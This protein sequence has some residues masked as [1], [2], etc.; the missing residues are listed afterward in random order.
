[1]GVEELYRKHEGVYSTAVGYIGG[2]TDE[3]T[4]KQVCA[5]TT[6]HAEAVQVHF[7]AEEVSFE[8]LLNIFWDNHNPTTLNR[9]DSDEG[10]QYRSAI[11]Y[12]SEEQ[13]NFAYESKNKL[14]ISKRFS[15]PIVTEIVRPPLSIERRNTIKNTYIKEELAV[16]RSSVY[17]LKYRWWFLC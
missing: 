4:Y 13:K 1:M 12:H 14:D 6:G 3:P 15:K 5:D 7:N 10:S 16:V 9:Q 8:T 11:F 17:A 2:Q